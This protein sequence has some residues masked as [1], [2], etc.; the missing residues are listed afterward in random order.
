MEV[1]DLTIQTAVYKTSKK[2]LCED[3]IFFFLMTTFSLDASLNYVSVLLG[4]VCHIAVEMGR[5][6][7]P[8]AVAI[9]GSRQ[10]Q[11]AGYGV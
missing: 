6:V 8:C 2:M 1:K 11:T 3:F 7:D 4:N 10:V 5:G 9:K